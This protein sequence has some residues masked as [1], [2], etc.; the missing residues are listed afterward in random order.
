[1]TKSSGILPAQVDLS[2]DFNTVKEGIWKINNKLF[3]LEL[4]VVG[5]VV[6]RGIPNVC[7]HHNIQLMSLMCEHFQRFCMFAIGGMQW[8]YAV[9]C[10]SLLVW[11]RRRLWFLRAG[12]Q[13]WFA[14]CP[15]IRI[16]KSTLLSL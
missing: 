13:S 8:K 4:I 6:Y 7:V 2:L 5:C 15:D 16:V 14:S 11:S 12:C 10:F 1:M 9:R 3:A